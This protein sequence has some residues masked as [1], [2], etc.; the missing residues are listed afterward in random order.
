MTQNGGRNELTFDRSQSYKTRG[1]QQRIA[2]RR[3]GHEADHEQRNGHT[4]WPDI[5]KIIE[6]H[7]H[8]A[9]YPGIRKAKEPCA[10]RHDDTENHI[11][12]GHDCY[13]GR[14]ILLDIIGGSDKPQLA[15]AAREEG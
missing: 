13:V 14:E 2:Q 1:W 9:K 10:R 12:A 11:D 15:L 7:G 4:S 6:D 8:P 5:G 3:K